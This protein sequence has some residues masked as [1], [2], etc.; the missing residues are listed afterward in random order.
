MYNFDFWKFLLVLTLV[1]WANRVFKSFEKKN[2]K[3]RVLSTLFSKKVKG[4]FFPNKK[5]NLKKKQNSLGLEK[6]QEVWKYGS[7][8]P[9]IWRGSTLKV[10][11]KRLK[12]FFKK[13]GPEVMKWSTQ[14]IKFFYFC[15][16]F[17]EFKRKEEQ[18]KT[19]LKT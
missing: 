18:V 4:F 19:D 9:K 10:H 1:K 6:N 2:L 3:T 11:S 13:S 14:Y 5:Q 7:C 17:D 12:F 15:Y 16:V 8:G